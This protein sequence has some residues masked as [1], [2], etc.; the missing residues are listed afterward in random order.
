MTKIAIIYTG[1]LR[2]CT[3]TLPLLKQHLHDYHVF[4]VIQNEFD[5]KEY[6]GDN[7]KSCII[8][9]KHEIDWVV[10]REKLIKNMTIPVRWEQYLRHSGSMIEYYQMY[11]AYKKI[12][13]FEIAHQFSYDYILKI[14]TDTVIKDPI[15]FKTDYNEDE[16][17]KIV[18]KIKEDHSYATIAETLPMF[19]N[20]FFNEKRL[21]YKLQF[22]NV[23]H[24]NAFKQLAQIQN[25]D[26]FIRE[27]KEYLIHGN[28]F[29]GLRVNN[30]YFVKRKIITAIHILGITYGLYKMNDDYWF[31]AESQLKQIC[32]EN[33]IDFYSSCTELEGKSLYAYNHENYMKDQLIDNEYS[34]FI[35]RY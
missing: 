22:E 19:M 3:T 29:I 25:E 1:E 4:A 11:L 7:L 5:L 34:F 15:Q 8:L 28:Y 21:Q 18:Y 13:E 23:L 32:V 2:T 17:K 9:D 27:L 30:V 6:M 31:N 35:K 33:N 24:T 16:I 26:E 14:R 10:L 12:E 20:V